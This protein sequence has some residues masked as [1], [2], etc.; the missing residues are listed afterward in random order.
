[1]RRRRWLAVACVVWA[2]SIFLTSSTVVTPQ[3]FF[4]WFGENVFVTD[5]SL[6]RFRLFWGAVW[7]FVVKGWHVTEFAILTWL[8][9][10]A[11]DAFTGR[12]DSRNVAIGVALSAIYAASDEWH[13]TFVPWR[14]G[15]VTDVLI[16]LIGVLG[17]GVTRLLSRRRA[18]Q[19][20]SPVEEP[21]A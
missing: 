11:L 12:R 1:M 19:P 20:V 13:Q 2:A 15:H 8:A 18:N 9:I 4:A 5:G 17:V 16:D 7:I 10:S 14:G 21:L 6:Q 3:A